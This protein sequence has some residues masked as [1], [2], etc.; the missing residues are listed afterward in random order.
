LP[1]PANTWNEAAGGE[2]VAPIGR[3]LLVTLS[4]ASVGCSSSSYYIVNDPFT[5]KTY[6]TKDVDRFNSGNVT[7]KDEKTGKKVS[8][9][10][11][12]VQ[13]VTGPE[14]EKALNATAPAEVPAPKPAP[15]PVAPTQ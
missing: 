2:I 15:A 6:Y 7:F 9:Q 12:E 14:Y 8:I 3:I 1:D 4:L 10:N 5:G 11:S 13:E